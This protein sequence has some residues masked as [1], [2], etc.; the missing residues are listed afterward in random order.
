MKKQI[1]VQG[2]TQNSQHHKKGPRTL[3]STLASN[4]IFRVSKFHTY[5][6]EYGSDLSLR[7][8]TRKNIFLFLNQNICC[9]CS[10]E[11]PY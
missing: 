10:K 11:P 2:K 6:F 8:H 9:G 7:V 1:R 5:K 3:V 4:K